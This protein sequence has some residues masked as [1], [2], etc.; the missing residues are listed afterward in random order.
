[1]CRQAAATA[2]QWRAGVSVFLFIFLFSFCWCLLGVLFVLMVGG[3]VL[4][5]SASSFP[6]SL[7]LG[8]AYRLLGRTSGY[9][10]ICTILTM[11]DF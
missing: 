3:L 6:F 7:L 1:M 5:F 8:Y 2:G 10:C 9:R 11:R 4:F